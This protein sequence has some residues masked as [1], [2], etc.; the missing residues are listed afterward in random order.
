MAEENEKILTIPLKN[1]RR[2]PK[3]QRASRAIKEIREFVARHMRAADGMSDEEK[4]RFARPTE[5][6]WI[7][8]KV[9]EVIWSRGIE[10]PP[11]EIR[12]RAIKF[13]DGLIEVSL[14]E[15]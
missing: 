9:N 1:T 7:D 6:I 14:P 2:A 8:S 4:E 10:K 5:K 15:E 13:E 11:S 12:V 3:S